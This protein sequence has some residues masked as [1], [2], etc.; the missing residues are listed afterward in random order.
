[1]HEA[2]RSVHRLTTSMENNYPAILKRLR[3]IESQQISATKKL[4]QAS[5]STTTSFSM[6]TSSHATI[7]RSEDAS[8]A[9][10][11][12]LSHSFRLTFENDVA[13]SRVYKKIF[14]RNPTSSFF[15]TK[16][17][18]TTLSMISGL[19]VADTVSRISVLGLAIV[20]SG[21]YNSE[22]YVDANPDRFAIERPSL[23]QAEEE[24]ANTLS[25]NTIDE[26]EK[27]SL[28][29]ILTTFQPLFGS[30]RSI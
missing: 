2:R 27:V 28:S 16:E 17:P 22:Q 29:M 12:R 6:N 24:P 25:Y 4:T 15:T 9:R 23:D 13:G 3:A 5:C 14:P 30:S 1:M 10:D 21:V 20:S 7:R 18:K 11:R 19:S 8:V 26:K